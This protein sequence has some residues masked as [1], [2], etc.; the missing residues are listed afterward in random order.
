MVKKKYIFSILFALMA[1]V[2]TSCDD[3]F[4]ENEGDCDVTHAIRFVYDM[5]LKWADAFPSEVNSVNLYVFDSNGVFV[6]EYIGRGEELSNPDYQ[7]MLDLKPGKYQF[8]AWCGLENEGA[9]EESFYVPTPEAGVTTI[10]EMNCT[11]TALKNAMNSRANEVTSD[12]RLDFLYHGYLEQ[13]L[14]DNHDGSHYVYT[15][16][17][18]KDTNHIRIMLQ[19]STGNLSTEDFEIYMTAE[20]GEMAWNNSLVGNTTIE[21]QPWNM[22]TDIL[23]V[24]NIN[25][26]QVEYTGVIADLSTCRLMANQTDNIYLNVLRKE[27]GKLLFKVP[28]I[29]YS[30]TT[31]SYYEMAYGH[32]MSDQEF[33][34]R[35]DEYLMTF[36]LDENMNWMYAVIDILQ[37]RVVVH[38]YSLGF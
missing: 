19:Q 23:G 32:S 34:D 31:K 30:L 5:N 10:Q 6:K 22:E 8:L 17:L 14:V 18:T 26:Q 27:D 21:Y 13:T 15:I 16:Y 2:T 7:I 24:A 3:H 28:L 12:Q 20:N 25:G 38:N 35:E 36:F 4:F 9:A 11:L 1:F 33:L 37:W 29:Q